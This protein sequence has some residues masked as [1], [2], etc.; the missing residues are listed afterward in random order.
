MILSPDFWSKGLFQV[1]HHTSLDV[2]LEICFALPPHAVRMQGFLL[3]MA[4][5]GVS[6][7]AERR[8]QH[9]G[10]WT[11]AGSPARLSGGLSWA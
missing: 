9:M 1:W 7:T 11:A 6:G 3:G 8:Y 10:W 2:C 4:G 5:G